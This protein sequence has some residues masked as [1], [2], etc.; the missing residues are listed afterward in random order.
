MKVMELIEITTVQR[1]LSARHSGVS[2]NLSAMPGAPGEYRAFKVLLDSEDVKRLVLWWEFENHTK[3]KSCYLVDVLESAAINPRVKSFV[4]GNPS[5]GQKAVDLR[6]LPDMEPVIV[7]NDL[8]SR[9]LY[10]IDGNHRTLGQHLSGK[11]FQDVPAYVCVHPKMMD[12]A[13]IPKYHKR[14]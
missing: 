1:H 14:R 5:K 7:T 13:Y 12:W 9:F 3:D 10:L 8:E 6:T 4:D 2:L 11:G